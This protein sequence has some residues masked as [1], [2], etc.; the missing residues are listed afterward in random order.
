LT[1]QQPRRRPRDDE[2]AAAF[3]GMGQAVAAIR[4]RHGMS[5]DELAAKAEMTVPEL[6]AVERGELDEWWGGLRMIAKA[7]DMPL[8]ELVIEA[9]AFASGEDKDG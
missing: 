5:R 3:R 7:F 1:R 8:A 6:E 2:E 4:E 9:D